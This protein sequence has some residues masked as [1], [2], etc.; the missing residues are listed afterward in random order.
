MK[1]LFIPYELAKLAKEKGFNNKCFGY[2]NG[3]QLQIKFD[4]LM[5]PL[6]MNE[7]N[8]EAP[9]YQQ[10]VDWFR[11]KHSLIIIT[12]R[13]SGFFTAK[14]CDFSDEQERIVKGTSEFSVAELDYYKTLTTAIEAA[15]KLI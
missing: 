9:M 12:E 4:Y 10:I 2:F 11:E 13:D 3:Q 8:L 7:P 14:V 6:D 1:H 15:F 5:G